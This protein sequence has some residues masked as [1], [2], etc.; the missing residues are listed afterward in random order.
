VPLTTV[1]GAATRLNW[2]LYAVSNPTIEAPEDF[3]ANLNY[4]NLNN[5]RAGVPA[6]H[7]AEHFDT[8]EDYQDGT[9]TE[10]FVHI[11]SHALLL[12][13]ETPG[14][15]FGLN[16]NRWKMHAGY[17]SDEQGET[18]DPG[19]EA[20]FATD[21]FGLAQYESSVALTRWSETDAPGGGTEWTIDDYGAPV[22]LMFYR[23]VQNLQ[24]GGDAFPVA[25]NHVWKERVGAGA[26]LDIKDGSTVLGQAEWSLNWEGEYGLYQKAWQQWH[27]M[28]R[29]GK[30][31]TQTFVIP[32]QVLR[33]FSFE[34]KIR[35][36]NMDF[37]LISDITKNF[38]SV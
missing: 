11:E 18:F 30:H 3:P 7:N 10:R 2:T 24:D 28:L 35:V 32:L 9:P 26:R 5:P 25:S 4:A 33:E 36:G 23:G 8:F 37:F 22:A 21:A 13:R 38:W 34:D 15:V 27:T 19:M 31:V 12:D 6:P 14:G 1:L 20:L 29:Q 16:T 17:Y